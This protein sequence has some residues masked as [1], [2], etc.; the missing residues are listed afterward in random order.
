MGDD[1]PGV[2]LDGT[3]YGRLLA[4]DP[5]PLRQR[6]KVDAFVVKA[7]PY[8]VFASLL[9]TLAVCVHSGVWT[10][11]GVLLSLA[12][13]FVA[14]FA[15]FGILCLAVCDKGTLDPAKW[16]PFLL[17]V[18][19]AFAALLYLVGN[20]LFPPMLTSWLF[21]FGPW[22]GFEFNLDSDFK[23]IALLTVRLYL[24]MVATFL[25]AH[26]VTS[27]LSAHFRK[28]IGRVYAYIGSLRNDGTDSPRGRFVLWLYKIPSVIDIDRV[29]LRDEPY[30]NDFDMKA[31]TALLVSV[32]VLGVV[33]SSYLFLNPIFLSRMSFTQIIL[34]AMAL[35]SFMPALVIPWYN[36]RDTGARVKS[37]ARDYYLWEGMKTTLYS[38]FFAFGLLFFLFILV[39]YYG[40]DL[41]RVA[42]TYL[43]YLI[44]MGFTSTIVSFVYTNHYRV[45]LNNGIIGLFGGKR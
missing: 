23:K 2:K 25:V 37:Q 21:E 44:F 24:L 42:L 3:D 18:P 9:L 34:V 12:L 40:V 14:V 36:A 7:F 43:G 31:F 30:D 22:M 13:S 28:Y 45:G 16:A 32:Y 17:I 27:T 26:G 41:E 1:D 33:I 11:G 10:F 29:E 20:Y 4:R 6:A 5:D 39:I 38:G 19:A 8:V 35:S 15:V